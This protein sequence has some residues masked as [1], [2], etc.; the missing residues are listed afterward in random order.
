MI[1][2]IPVQGGHRDGSLLIFRGD[3]SRKFENFVES[4]NLFYYTVYLSDCSCRMEPISCGTRVTLMFDLICSDPAKLFPSVGADVVQMLGQLQPNSA[5]RLLAIPLDKSEQSF[6]SLSTR[7][8]RLVD[9]VSS[10]NFIDIRLAIVCRYR[11]GKVIY[12][13]AIDTV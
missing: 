11:I 12:N 5:D 1:V 10:L 13:I 3:Q 4:S 7:S 8:R 6:S 9:L 2:Q